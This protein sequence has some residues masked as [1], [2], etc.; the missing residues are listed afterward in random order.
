L[1]VVRGIEEGL[2]AL[3][4]DSF[5][6]VQAGSSG[7]MEGI[8]R[9]FGEALTLEQVVGQ[10]IH[11]VSNRG[12]IAVREYTK[13]IDGVDLDILELDRGDIVRAVSEVPQETTDALRRASN[14]VREFHVACLP[15]PWMDMESGFGEMITPIERVGIY[16]PGG[17]ASYPSTVLMTA[18]PAKVA[19]VSEIIVATPPRKD[20]GPNPNVLAAAMITGVGRVFQ[21]GG[22]Q[23]IAAMAYGTESIPKVDMICGPGNI[24]VTTAKKMVYGQ[25]N[26]DGLEGPTETMIIADEGANPVFCAADLLAQA[27]H[28]L[29]A[30][31]ILVTTSPG[32]IPSIQ[33]ELQ[34]Q[35][36]GLTRKNTAANSIDSRGVFVIVDSLDEA[37]HLANHYAPEHL[38]LMIRE[39]WSAVGKVRNAGGVFLGDYSPEA[40]GD[41]VAGPSHVM[42]TGGTARF[43]S[44]LGVGQFLKRTPL[45]ALDLN[46]TLR[47]ARTASTLARTEGFD[48][49]ARSVEVR[50]ELQ[51]SESEGQSQLPRGL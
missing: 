45:V 34:K 8:Q 51:D 48:A 3:S 14:R 50:V 21:V 36:E 47:F 30:T 20:Q 24:F 23:A 10:I 37:V 2:K 44:S 28:D 9:I 43:N 5:L 26:V 17:M 1:K 29:L 35:L 15:R 22:A 49:H 46:T 6:E 38:C 13:L 33:D 11:Q 4:R 27:E 25:V 31:P 16:I 42:P 19:G 12:D 39:P 32:L 18:I 7:V 40:M 41:Y